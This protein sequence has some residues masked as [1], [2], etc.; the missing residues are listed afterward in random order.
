MV[1]L[2]FSNSVEVLKRRALTEQ[3]YKEAAILGWQVEWLRKY[4]KHTQH[5]HS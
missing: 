3:E 4:S 1:D 2:T 5:E